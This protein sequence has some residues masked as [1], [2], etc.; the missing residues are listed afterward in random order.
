[1]NRPTPPTLA[2]TSS[3]VT[4]GASPATGAAQ[5]LVAAGA[6]LAQVFTLPSVPT[7]PLDAYKISQ[8]PLW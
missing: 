8:E 2:E 5:S 4:S 7:R 6:D 1:M 3:G